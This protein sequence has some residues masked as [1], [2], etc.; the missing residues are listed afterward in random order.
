MR[1]DYFLYMAEAEGH[2]ELVD[3]YEARMNAVI[4]DFVDAYFSGENINSKYLQ[5]EIG[6]KHGFGSGFTDR[7]SN[8]IEQEVSKRIYN[9]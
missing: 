3:T 6:I 2:D 4:Y 9:R 8:F 7:E 1:R 5:R